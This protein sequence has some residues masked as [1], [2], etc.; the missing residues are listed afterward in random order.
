MDVNEDKYTL[1][2]L[3]NGRPLRPDVGT[4][5]TSQSHFV[6]LISLVCN[7]PNQKIYYYSKMDLEHNI[8]I[9]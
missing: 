3:D 6:K 2:G 7:S 9:L 5:K 1:E 4:G 8:I